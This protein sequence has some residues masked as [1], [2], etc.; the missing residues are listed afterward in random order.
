[1]ENSY[2]HWQHLRQHLLHVTAIFCSSWCK[3]M[4]K[5]LENSSS[6]YEA[7]HHMAWCTCHQEPVY[8]YWL[9]CTYIY[10]HIYIYTYIVLAC[11][12]ELLVHMYSIYKVKV[13][14][15]WYV[16]DM[17]MLWVHIYIC[18]YMHAYSNINYPCTYACM[19]VATTYI[20]HVHIYL[21]TQYMY[22]HM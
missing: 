8:M 21:A 12:Q 19:H 9:L 1:M 3:V 17:Y 7:G 13:N 4:S 15:E 14:T 11:L 10:V 22:M 6:M 16:L 2:R 5:M 20:W 18:M